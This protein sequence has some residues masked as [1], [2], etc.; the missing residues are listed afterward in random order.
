MPNLQKIGISSGWKINWAEYQCKINEFSATDLDDPSWLD[1]SVPGDVHLELMSEGV[2]PD[3]F[4]G[5]NCELIRWMEEKDWWY[6]THFEIPASW[7]AEGRSIRLFFH[8]LDCFATVY[9]NGKEIGRHSNMFTPFEVDITEEGNSGM[10]VLVVRLASPVLTPLDKS[11][12]A[13]VW[14]GFPRQLTRKAQMSYGWDIAPRLVTIGIW[15]PVELICID[16]YEPTSY[17]NPS[18]SIVL[19]HSCF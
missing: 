2:I 14:W 7:D 12:R 15:R 16:L 17:F 19:L 10:N 4:V 8:G 13:P 1:A 3:P 6:R 18:N 11:S 9:L 5:I